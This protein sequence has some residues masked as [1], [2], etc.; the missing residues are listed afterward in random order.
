MFDW[1]L[2]LVGLVI[3]AAVSWIAGRMWNRLRSFTDSETREI[4]CISSC[5]GC[6]VS[7]GEC[8]QGKKS[9]LSSSNKTRQAAFTRRH[10]FK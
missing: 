9:R 7:G 8:G 10:T 5:S 6:E 2:L 3:A 1:Q 4:N